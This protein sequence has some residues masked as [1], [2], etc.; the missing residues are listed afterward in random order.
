[1]KN[2]AMIRREWKAEKKKIESR[3]DSE[4]RPRG[5]GFRRKRK[6]RTKS[7]RGKGFRQSKERK[8]TQK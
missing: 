3:F 4:G 2:L 5:E 7:E 8:R 1:M 6:S